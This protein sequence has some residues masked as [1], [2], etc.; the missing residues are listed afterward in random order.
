M[1]SNQGRRREERE[2]L[3]S[4]EATLLASIGDPEEDGMLNYYI[5]LTGKRIFGKDGVEFKVDS[6]RKNK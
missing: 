5:K 6:S 3:C 4:T 2:R 1:S